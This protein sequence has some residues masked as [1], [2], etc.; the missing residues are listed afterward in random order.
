MALCR[1]FYP[2]LEI[3]LD[4]TTLV[5]RGRSNQDALRTLA[6]SALAELVHHLR[7]QLTDAQLERIVNMFARCTR[8]APACMLCYAQGKCERIFQ[9]DTVPNTGSSPVLE[10]IIVHSA[11]HCKHI[12][13]PMS[14]IMMHAETMETP[15]P[16]A[17]YSTFRYGATFRPSLDAIQCNAPSQSCSKG[18]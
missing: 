15:L 9:T 6:Y 11:A 13:R 17:L 8:F 16:L 5:G 3:L 1:P 2:K 4:E 12:G 18:S 10:H 14:C 7:Q